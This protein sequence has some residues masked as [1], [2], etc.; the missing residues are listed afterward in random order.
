MFAESRAAYFRAR[1]DAL[2]TPIAW[3]LERLAEGARLAGRL[4]GE[5]GLGTVAAGA[6]ADLVV[7]DY[8]APTPLGP[9]NLA[10]HWMFGLGAAHVRDVVAAGDLVVEDRRLTRVD[11]DG[12]AADAAVQAA[13]LWERL[14]GVPAH[15]FSPVGGAA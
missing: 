1:D 5:P 8:A 15:G 3:P 6:P 7:L 11:Q 13:A 14:E 10:G 12:L 4:F 9:T 2:G